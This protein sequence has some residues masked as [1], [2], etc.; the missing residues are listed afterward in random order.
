MRVQGHRLEQVEC[1][2]PRH[3]ALSEEADRAE[4][5]F[6]IT[7]K[8]V[9]SRS[10]GAMKADDVYMGVAF[11]AGLNKVVVPFFDYGTPVE[12]ELVR[13]IPPWPRASARRS[14]CW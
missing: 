9:F 6:G 11:T 7:A 14:A 12:Y 2:D 4:K 3:R 8:Q 10:R 13:S 5:L 1:A